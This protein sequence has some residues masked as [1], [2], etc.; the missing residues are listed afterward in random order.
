MALTKIWIKKSELSKIAARR[1]SRFRQKCL[2]FSNGSKIGPLGARDLI[3]ILKWGY[4]L[5]FQVIKFYR[6]P[7]AL[8]CLILKYS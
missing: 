8:K 7:E 1:N 3:P 2:K 5:Y 4:G 6:P